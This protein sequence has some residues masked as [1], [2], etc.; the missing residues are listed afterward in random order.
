M[1]QP[2]CRSCALRKPVP[3][4]KL[5]WRVNT[6]VSGEVLPYFE[7]FDLVLTCVGIGMLAFSLK[8]GWLRS[9][10]PE[11]DASLSRK[12]S[13]DEVCGRYLKRVEPLVAR[14]ATGTLDS[15]DGAARNYTSPG[16]RP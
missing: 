10:W 3:W 5:A 8:E 9:S 4:H 12:G 16:R 11:R 6:K 13:G 1:N 15:L 2:H 7:A 14:I